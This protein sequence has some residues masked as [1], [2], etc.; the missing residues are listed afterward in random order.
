MSNHDAGRAHSGA[1]ATGTEY[2]LAHLLERLA[3]GH[4]GE[5]GVRAEV[6]GEAVQV[7]GTVASAQC[8]EE[9]LV[10]VREELVGIPVHCDLV[11]A[12]SSAPGQAEELA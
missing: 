10:M 7:T 9:I 8:R 2:R 6:R 12:E 11:V 4:P 5:L 1:P 3:A